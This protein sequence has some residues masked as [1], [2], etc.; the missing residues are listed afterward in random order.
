MK[1]KTLSLAILFLTLSISIIPSN[2]FKIDI[3]KEKKPLSLL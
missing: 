3:S 1:N 2:A